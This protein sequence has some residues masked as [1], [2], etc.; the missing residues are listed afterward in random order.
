MVCV[1]GYEF[2]LKLDLI[3]IIIVVWILICVSN[4]LCLVYENIYFNG[5]LCFY[6]LLGCY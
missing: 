4:F 3:F 1:C 6:V 5:W 2:V